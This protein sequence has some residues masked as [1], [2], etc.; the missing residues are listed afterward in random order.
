VYL[1]VNTEGVRT[2][3]HTFLTEK[4]I[5][6]YHHMI[7]NGALRKYHGKG[8][9]SCLINHIVKIKGSRLQVDVNEQN[10]GACKFYKRFGFVRMGRS[11]LDGSGKPFPLLHLEYTI[12]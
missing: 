11:E 10:H 7:K 12:T 8:I 2:V 3:T 9:G 6:F 1:N 4:D 5:Q